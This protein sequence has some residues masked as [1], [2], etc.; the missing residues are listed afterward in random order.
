MIQHEFIKKKNKQTNK[1]TNLSN[2]KQTASPV[3][4]LPHRIIDMPQNTR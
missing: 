1:E 4:Q 3:A 2:R